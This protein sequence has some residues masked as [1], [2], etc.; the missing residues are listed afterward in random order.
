MIDQSPL[1]AARHLSLVPH[2]STPFTSRRPV[3]PAVVRFPADTEESMVDVVL[4]DGAATR[5]AEQALALER[6]RKEAFVSTLAHEL[7]QPLSAC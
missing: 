4:R 1:F 6:Q 7:R 5:R 2:T 3:G